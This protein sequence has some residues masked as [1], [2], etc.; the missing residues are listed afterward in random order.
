M[1]FAERMETA[2]LTFRNILSL[3]RMNRREQ[4]YLEMYVPS[5]HAKSLKASTVTPPIRM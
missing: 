4:K 3:G 1:E 5:Y 2:H